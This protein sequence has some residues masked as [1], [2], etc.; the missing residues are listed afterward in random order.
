MPDK[1]ATIICE[2][3]DH[4]LVVETGVDHADLTYFSFF[5]SEWYASQRTFV[6]TWIKS[7]AGPRSVETWKE[8]E[9]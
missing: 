7:C 6:G 9:S 1:Q 3:Q 4:V 2:G 5:I 8:S